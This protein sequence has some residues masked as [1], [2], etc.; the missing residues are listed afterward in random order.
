MRADVAIAGAG[1]AGL[2]CAAL[3]ADAGL[4]VVVLERSAQAGGRARSWM[5]PTTGVEIDVGPHVLST[6]HRNFLGLMQRV[7][8]A[9]ALQWQPDPLVTVLDR[10]GA[11]DIA[12]GRAPPPLHGLP[13]LPA[14]LSRLSWP[15]LLSHLR[16]AWRAARLDEGGLQAYDGEDMLSLLRRLGVR[17]GP[18]EWF[19]RS[20]LLALLNVRLEDC[21]AA[22]GLRVFRL[23]LGRSGYH[24]ALPQ[25]GLSQLYVPGCRAAVARAGGELVFDAAA[26]AVRAED[27]RAT[28][29]VLEDGR[30]IEAA[31][32][33][34]A[35][36]P[37]E[38][39]A[40]L[41]STGAPALEA[42][43]SVARRFV[44]SPYV[45]TYLW[46]DR[47]LRTRAFWARAWS[48]GDLNTDFYDLSRIRPGLAAGPALIASN[49]IGPLARS[50]WDDDRI[51]QRTL[52]EL[53]DLDPAARGA[54]VV[55][56]RVHRIPM[57]VPQPRPGTERL[58]PPTRTALDRLWLAGDWTATAVPCSMESAARS[59]ALAAEAVL[60]QVGRPA[61][62]A[63]EAPETYG[64]PGLL[65]RLANG[66]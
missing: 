36:P 23:M 13:A 59:G 47:P 20:G 43:R 30:H 34:L 19:W 6:E 5:D 29:I 1:V 16:L 62:L 18:I 37:A 17:A 51:V 52:D 25:V 9:G 21:S 14:A 49:S 8:T 32:C 45:S 50:D 42:L 58:R 60:Q 3:L 39:A 38:L 66:G 46:L 2:A 22:A 11:L 56:A 26:H 63:I 64:L 24:F 44:P 53:A 15:D 57:A 7:G 12:I 48:A 65:R 61:R 55:H 27:G 35:L 28:A 33:V 10:L 31:H 41:N 4:R 40:V 54:R